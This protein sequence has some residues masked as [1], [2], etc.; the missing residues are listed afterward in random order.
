MLIAALLVT[1][2]ANLLAQ[3]TESERQLRIFA[4][5]TTYVVPIVEHNGTPYVGLFEVLEPLGRVESHSDKQKWKLKFTAASSR[6]V[7]VEF[8]K[9]RPEANSPA[10]VTTCPPSLCCLAAE[11]LCR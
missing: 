10:W 1:W 7:E 5:Q 4:S 3:P 9:G 8:T 6:S 11:A 2:L